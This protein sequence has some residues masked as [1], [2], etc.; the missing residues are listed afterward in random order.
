METAAMAIKAKSDKAGIR[1]LAYQVAQITTQATKNNIK[2]VDCL[3]TFGGVKDILREVKNLD[4]KKRID[5]ILIYSPSQIAKSETEYREFVDA[6]NKDY[7]IA[8][9]CIRS[10]F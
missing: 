8:V 4:A 5:S 7:K 1:T 9:R 10:N 6:L 3:V 2:I